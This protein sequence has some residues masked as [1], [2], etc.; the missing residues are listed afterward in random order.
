MISYGT[1]HEDV[2]LRRLFP[3]SAEGFYVDVGAGD[4]VLGSVTKHFYDRGWRGINVEPAVPVFE[5][6][7]SQ[8]PRDVNLNVGVAA[9]EGTLTFHEAP[10]ELHGLSTFSAALAAQHRARGVAFV[11]KRVPVTTLARVLAEHAPA[12]I[13]FLTV[14]VEGFELEVLQG[15]DWEA[16]RPRVVVVEAVAPQLLTAGGDA[17]SPTLTHAAWEPVLLA[18]GY[19]FGAFDGLNRYYVRQEDRALAERL[20]IPVNVFDGFVPYVHLVQLESAQRRLVAVHQLHRAVAT[21]LE[22]LWTA[23]LDER[24]GLRSRAWRSPAPISPRPVRRLARGR[25]STSGPGPGW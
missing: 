16:W 24:Q 17:V 10:D 12:S 13:D 4:P 3:E 5:R 1:N 8:R 9:G 19:V 7:E 18:A 15:S 20:T 2:L 6:L 25:C 11:E 22:E 21:Q 23:R 14:D